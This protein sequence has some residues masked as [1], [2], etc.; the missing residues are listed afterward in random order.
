[1]QLVLPFVARDWYLSE[2]QRVSWAW[3]VKVNVQFAPGPWTEHKLGCAAGKM[4]W[5]LSYRFPICEFVRLY[6]KYYDGC[7]LAAADIICQF[8]IYS[9]SFSK[10][11]HRCFIP[12]DHTCRPKTRF[13]FFQ[14]KHKTTNGI[15]DVLKL[16]QLYDWT[17]GERN[18]FSTIPL[19]VQM[20]ESNSSFYW[21]TKD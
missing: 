6:N 12:W 16:E 5:A 21:D 15:A 3:E 10:A 13:F 18:N 4:C 19:S 1:M 14:K 8:C 7:Y 9:S 20:P 2:K 11:N 17:G